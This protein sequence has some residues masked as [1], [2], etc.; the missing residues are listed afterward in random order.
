MSS[1]QPPVSNQPHPYRKP[2]SSLPSYSPHLIRITGGSI[3]LKSTNPF[4]HPLISPNLLSHPLDIKIMIEAI[5]SAR[6]FMAA[7]AWDGWI[8]DEV[9]PF[10][11]AKT[12]EEIE[13]YVRSTSSTVNHV[14]CTMAMGPES[15]GNT[16]GKGEGALEPDLRVK[17]TMGLK[18][19]DASA[20]VSCSLRLCRAGCLSCRLCI[21]LSS[22]RRMRRPRCMLWRRGRQI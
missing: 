9:P 11:Q 7:R 1:P 10:K 13:A 19:V 4:D 16:S 5:E 21:S 14:C 17:G 3:S 6:R 12:D 2:P 20:F 18:V 8:L 22:P 15:G